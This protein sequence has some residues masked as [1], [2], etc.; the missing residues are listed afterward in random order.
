MVADR[1]AVCSKPVANNHRAIQCDLC[2]KWVHIKCKLL[3]KYDYSY[4]NKPKNVDVPFYCI[5]CVSDSIPCS[6]LNDNEFSVLIKKGVNNVNDCRADFS[7]SS[8]QQKVFDDL[9]TAIN[10]NAFDIDTE[11]DEDGT[12]IPTI[13]CRYYSIDEFLSFFLS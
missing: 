8:F 6:K 11:D 2:N 10:N 7:P 5:N 13:D 9:N 4:L 12:V 1:C 3:N